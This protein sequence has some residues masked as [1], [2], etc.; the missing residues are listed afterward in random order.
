M[1]NGRLTIRDLTSRPRVLEAIGEF[2]RLGREQF[3]T[4]YDYGPLS[5]IAFA[6]RA[7]S[8]TQRQSQVSPGVFSTTTPLLYGWC[9]HLGSRVGEARL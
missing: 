7:S 8:M 6:T 4:R 3:L 5:A 9:P 1:A 2:D